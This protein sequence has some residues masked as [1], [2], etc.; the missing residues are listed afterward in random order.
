MRV[1]Y[2]YRNI[3]EEDKILADDI[4]V[5]R[6]EAGVD[7][8]LD[9]RFDRG[10]SHR[11]ARIWIGGGQYWIEDLGSRNGTMVNGESIHGKGC[12]SLQEGDVIQIGDTTLRLD[13]KDEPPKN[14]DRS[15]ITVTLDAR[16]PIY[17]TEESAYG[18]AERRLAILYEL[19][20]QFG[21]EVQLD[22]LL[23]MIVSKLVDLIP[24]SMRA[25]LALKDAAT[26]RLLLKAHVP[27]G[28]P[29]M[30]M[31]LAQRALD[32]RVGFIW[33]RETDQK[34][35]QV[36]DM[37]DCA[38]YA[39]LLWK[40]KA[41]GVIVLDNY[42]KA[43]V[44]ED[45][46]LKLLMAI[47][48]HAAM[49]VANQVL[50]EELRRES[51]TKSNLLRQF[52]PKIAERILSHRGRLQL[53]GERCEATVLF[54]DIRGFSKLSRNMEP[55]AVV[56]LLNYYFAGLLPI[57]FAYD[58]S[59]DK[60][61][62]D[63]ILSVF[64]SPEPDPAQFEKAV[65]A[66]MGMQ[67]KMRELNFARETAGDVPCY[68]GIGVHCGEVVQGFV[69]MPDRMAFAVIGDTVNRA[70]R[71]CDGA[72]AGEVL[73]S[74]ELY[75]RVWRIIHHAEQVTVDAKYQEQFPAYRI[76]DLWQ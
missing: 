52:S 3:L 59:V 16:K 66:A 28:E 42:Q 6:H 5:G 41:L 30:S 48:Q 1:V 33:Q 54:A 39:P 49:A 71:Y 44:F 55:E 22:S 57:I 70:A 23:K 58:G 56:E 12:R 7:V 76:K 51:V 18:Q 25:A 60:Y 63:A 62:G 43:Y 45:D 20:L 2:C 53:G 15:T 14:D 68:I 69:G 72:K 13:L 24:E 38:M 35:T 26:G 11:H 50:Q 73:I 61:A 40:G 27:P 74:P 34:V 29:H 19:P 31:T 8:D 46:D 65:R 36:D 64:G 47:A 32:Q 37:A 9:L 10:I 17:S 21:G 67:E 75:E 4:I